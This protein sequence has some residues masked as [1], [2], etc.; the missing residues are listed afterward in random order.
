[1]QGESEYR[2][3]LQPPF[4]AADV[5]KLTRGVCA[6]SL[7][8]QIGFQVRVRPGA[9]GCGPQTVGATHRIDSCIDNSVLEWYTKETQA[10]ILTGLLVRVEVL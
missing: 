1:M 3:L 8:F 6:L 9:C 10:I 7:P 2:G 5:A 4:R